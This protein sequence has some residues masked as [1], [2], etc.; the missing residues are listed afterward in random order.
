MALALARAELLAQRLGLQ[1][2]G[3]QRWAS[4]QLPSQRLP[5]QRRVSQPVRPVRQ[6]GA[7]SSVRVMQPWL[8]Q[9]GPLW[10]RQGEKPPQAHLPVAFPR[11]W[12][13]RPA[14]ARRGWSDWALLPGPETEVGP[15]GQ[16]PQR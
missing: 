14:A 9:P 3:S 5:S 10:L 12:G 7:V 1:R 16:Q 6:P 15:V 4:Q 2:L 8:P 11:G 13:Q